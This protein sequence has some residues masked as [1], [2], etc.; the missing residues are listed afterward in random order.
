[1][2]DIPMGQPQITETLSYFEVST[3]AIS[4]SDDIKKGYTFIVSHASL[5]EVGN[6]PVSISLYQDSERR[7]LKIYNDSLSPIN[8]FGIASN[9][10]VLKYT[11]VIDNGGYA[12]YRFDANFVSVK[13]YGQIYIR[14][15]N[16]WNPAEVCF[17]YGS[18]TVSVSL[19]RQILASLQSQS[20]STGSIVGAIE[21]STVEI[22]TQNKAVALEFWNKLKEQEEK[23]HEDLMEGWA[24]NKQIDTTVT[25]DYAAKDEELQNAT[26]DGRNKTVSIFNTFGSLFQSDGHLYKGLLSV[27]AIFN[28]FLKIDWVGSMLNFS[29]AIG[30]FAFVIGTGASVVRWV[31][32]RADSRSSKNDDSGG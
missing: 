13:P 1:M 14:D 22:T 31:H 25:D 16:G 32:E 24:P 10:D 11:T 6:I 8:I 7:I 23:Q 19:L 20:G 18:D 5:S 12:E 9:G 3:Q 29:L 28:E 4:G 21:D 17:N 27:T 15:I 30:V 26:S 2:I